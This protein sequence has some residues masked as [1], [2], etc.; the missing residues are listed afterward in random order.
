MIK[1]KVVQKIN[2]LIKKKNPKSEEIGNKQSLIILKL[3]CP[4]FFH[5]AKTS[6][7]PILAICTNL[8]SEVIDYQ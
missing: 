6:L 3:P 7:I 8:F 5:T 2:M 1:N 4:P